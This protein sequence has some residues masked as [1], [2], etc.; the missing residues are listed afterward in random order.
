MEVSWKEYVDVR[1]KE[2]EKGN[3]LTKSEMDR[4]LEGMNEFRRQ[5]DKQANT[6]ITRIEHDS[7]CDRIKSLELSRAELSGKASQSSVITTTIIASLGILIG[8]IG[9]VL[10]I[11][12]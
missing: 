9:L 3:I 5:L 10:A 8:V 7:V 2:L 12:K 11:L 4:R 1:L 6:F